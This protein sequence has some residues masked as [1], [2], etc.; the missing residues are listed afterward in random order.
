MHSGAGLNS[1]GE[2]LFQ[3]RD[4]DRERIMRPAIVESRKR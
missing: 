4:L 2:F 1:Q 3:F